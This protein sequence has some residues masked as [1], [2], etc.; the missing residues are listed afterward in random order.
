ML[1]PDGKVREAAVEGAHVLAA[2]IR[3]KKPLGALRLCGSK[4][5]PRGT[6]SLGTREEECGEGN[7]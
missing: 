3:V 4:P 2:H 5:T 6:G 1:R 7:Y